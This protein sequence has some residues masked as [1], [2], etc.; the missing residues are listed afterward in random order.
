L[1]EPT[2]ALDHESE[3]K[4]NEAIDRITREKTVVVV[5]HRLTTITNAD[6]IIV[7]NNGMIEEQGKH[8]EL[9]SQGGLYS[10]LYDEYQNG[11][12]V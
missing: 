10:E 2:S 7:V 5:A 6:N 9:I 1:D 4:V 3:T 11:R 8:V 12:A